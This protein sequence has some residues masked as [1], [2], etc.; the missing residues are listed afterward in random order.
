MKYRICFPGNKVWPK[1]NGLGSISIRLLSQSHAFLMWIKILFLRSESELV[2]STEFYEQN[3]Q[4]DLSEHVASPLQNHLLDP[5]VSFTWNS[6][7]SPIS[8]KFPSAVWKAEARGLILSKGTALWEGIMTVSSA[9]CF[10]GWWLLY[11]H[12]TLERARL[13]GHSI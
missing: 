1:I 13:S 8:Q 9:H 11:L 2:A 12:R 4:V 7:D 10:I 6:M 3:C 5:N